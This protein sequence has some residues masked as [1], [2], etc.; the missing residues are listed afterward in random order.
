METNASSE[1]LAFINANRQKKAA[2]VALSLSKKPEL[3]KE[4]ILNQISGYQ[5]ALK[6]LPFLTDFPDFIFPDPRAVAQSSSET[7][8]K[9]K[10]ELISE[11]KILDASGG[12]GMDSYFFSKIVSQVSYLEPNAAL[13][14][15]TRDNFEVLG[16]EN[17]ECFQQVAREYLHETTA[18]FD[19]VYLDPDRRKGALRKFRIEDCEPNVLELLPLIWKKT[20]RLLVKLSPMLDISYALEVFH[21]CKAVYIVS[22]DNE[23]KELLFLLEKD[24]KGIARIHAV[25]IEKTT[26]IEFNYELWE[27]QEASATYSRPL[28]F[29]YEPNASIL[30]GGAFNLLAKKFDLLKLAPNTHLYTSE[31]VVPDFP[32]RTIQIKSTG[33]PQKGL[34]KQA[35]VVCRNFHLRPEELKKKYKITDGGELFLYACTL[36]EK[37][38]VFI[39]GT[40]CKI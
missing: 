20:E 12:M 38:R 35:N 31:K 27:E 1:T 3:P 21:S 14:G 13:F 11:D 39:L 36:L 26:S 33:K 25:D 16:A 37:E 18:T 8:A 6:K 32:G 5:K 15:L 4:F 10:A 34:V 40:K 7:T 28:S 23:C 30:K 19:W 17:I 2:E 9:F 24:F 22:V 29:L